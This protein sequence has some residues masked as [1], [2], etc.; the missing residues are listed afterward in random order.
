MSYFIVTALFHQHCLF[1]EG[2]GEAEREMAAWM[3][4]K[5]GVKIKKTTFFIERILK[6]SFH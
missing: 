5:Q 1:W 4:F 3:D 2:G 6:L